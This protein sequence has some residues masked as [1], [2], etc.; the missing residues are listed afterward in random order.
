[1]KTVPIVIILLFSVQLGAQ[2]VDGPNDIDV[3]VE[4][5]D[6]A[7]TEDS[8]MAKNSE[9]TAIIDSYATNN[10]D[11]TISNPKPR[12]VNFLGVLLEKGSKTPI[13]DAEIYIKDTA[14]SATT[15]GEGAFA[16]YNLPEIKFEVVIPTTDYQTF[17][18]KE[19]IEKGKRTE[20]KYYLV[21]RMT[22]AMEVVIRDKK[23]E[24]EV[25]RS[26]IQIEEA[27]LV[28]GTGGDALKAIE[29]MPGVA[30]GM[31]G[32]DIVIRGSN[33]EDSKFYIDGHE[34]YSIFHFGGLKSTY[35]SKLIDSFELM[36]GGFSAQNGLATGGVINVKTRAPRNDRWGGYLDVSAID[37]SF[38]FEGPISDKME[39]AVAAR[40][41]TTD[42]ILNAIDLNKKIDGL[43]FTTYP[44]YWDYQTKWNY[45]INPRHTLRLD[46]YGDKD[47][48]AMNLDMVADSDPSLTGRM[49]FS[50][51]GHNVFLH[52]FYENGK[53]NNHFS[54]G[55]YLMKEENQVGEYFFNGDYTIFDI[56]D[57]LRIAL[58]STNT[59]GIG[60]GLTPR[61][62]G[63]SANMV[64]PPKE[65]DVGWSFT[66]SEPLLVE[67]TTSG[68]ISS[69]YI[70]DEIHIGNLFLVP[71]LR[72]D[73]ESKMNKAGLGPR[74][75]TRYQ[76]FKPFCIKASGGL[77]HRVP[78]FDEIDNYFGSKG[79]TMERA[80][81]SVAGFE[82]AIT[83]SIEADIQA[84]HKYL[85]N[86][87]T[88]INN[89]DDTRGY[90]NSGKGYV[91]GA[92][93][94]LRHNWTE[95]FFGWIS[96]SL[97][98][99]MRND[100]P[101]TD[102]RPFDMDQR[103][104]LIVVASWKFPKGWR[105]GLRFQYTSGE[106]YTEI[107]DHI[108]NGDE[109]NYIPIYDEDNKNQKSRSAY[110][111]LDLRLDK[112]WL[113]NTWVLHT[114]LDVQNV[115]MHKNEV[116]TIYNYDFSENIQITDL[117]ILPSIGVSAEF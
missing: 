36:T 43:N 111:R 46:V 29:S 53:I 73:H 85:D 23:V 14:F 54:P 12:V 88:G 113:F 30:R 78:D 60:V 95:R 47:G 38:L 99:S 4:Y 41:S 57:D 22:G 93:M 31:S 50:F 92:E 86:L 1:M 48:M 8:A 69:I 17:A 79:L 51:Q 16:F 107:T 28:P 9:S 97:S 55:V 39:V 110:H 71:S 40:R 13:P 109:G 34:I 83:D 42:L 100:G 58:T 82:W 81:H 49:D 6:R 116:D 90:N 45:R 27:E 61:I 11:E 56:K 102:Y 91:V 66:N 101:G 74:L 59:L 25:S 117:P 63:L 35:N 20:V 32:G 103:H 10:T 5:A 105:L 7:M 94:M 75:V 106:P 115:Y 26:I 84:Y 52:H 21:P 2:T 96:Y 114:Y 19:R 65:G 80:V 112:E 89:N 64:Q 24:K 72:L 76:I 18:T 67:N 15:D 37:G 62:A 77:Y 98:K 70:Q 104:N 87:V 68:I 108:Y 44:M 3:V 33:A